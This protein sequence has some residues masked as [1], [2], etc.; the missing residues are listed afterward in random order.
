VP[1]CGA[2]PFHALLSDTAN[3]H[4]VTAQRIAWSAAEASEL[5]PLVESFRQAT[6]EAKA[7]VVASLKVAEDFLKENAKAEPAAQEVEPALDKPAIEGQIE[8]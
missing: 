1:Y 2:N 6:D 8:K 7:T 4:L 5:R 3:N